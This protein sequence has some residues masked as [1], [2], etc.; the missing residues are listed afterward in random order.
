VAIAS[1]ATRMLPTF[2][3]CPSYSP[4][5]EQRPSALF[6]VWML[7]LWRACRVILRR[8]RVFA[9]LLAP[10]DTPQVAVRRGEAAAYVLAR[11]VG[12]LRW[13]VMRGESLPRVPSH[14]PPSE[15]CGVSAAHSQATA[16]VVQR[17]DGMA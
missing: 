1:R 10:G 14:G 8:S 11:A 6:G 16:A 13:R 5:G 9:P 2:A 15:R 3:P 12:A 4:G 7:P 17:S